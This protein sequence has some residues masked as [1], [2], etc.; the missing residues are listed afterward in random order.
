MYYD[1]S[2]SCTVNLCTAVVPLV[3][4]VRRMGYNTQ[5]IM[6]LINVWLYWYG[7]NRYQIIVAHRVSTSGIG[8]KKGDIIIA[9]SIITNVSW[10]LRG[11]AGRCSSRETPQPFGRT[12]GAQVIK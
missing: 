2:V 4:C 7:I 6:K 9:G 10:I 1:K 11:A 12:I 5:R 8:S 3:R